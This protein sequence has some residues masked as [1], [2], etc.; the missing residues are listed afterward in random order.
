MTAKRLLAKL[1]SVLNDV[2]PGYGVPTVFEPGYHTGGKLPTLA[3]DGPH[4]WITITG[5][6]SIWCG[7]YGLCY[8]TPLEEQIAAVLDEIEE[9][10]FFLEPQNQAVMCIHHA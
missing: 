3:W 10:G 8:S 1:A 9:N 5:R 6:A 7:A 4:D 2:A